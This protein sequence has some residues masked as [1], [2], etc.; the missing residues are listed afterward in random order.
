MSVTL[1]SADNTGRLSDCDCRLLTVA[2]P[3]PVH[4]ARAG[5]IRALYEF[6]RLEFI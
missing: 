4:F 2:R 3:C 1:F 5:R 6:G